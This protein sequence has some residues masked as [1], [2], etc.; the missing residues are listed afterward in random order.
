VDVGGESTRPGA[1]PVTDEEQIRRV[2]P[3]IEPLAELGEVSIDTRSAAVARAAVRAGARIINDVSA[4]LELVAAELGAGWVAMH[5]RGTPQTMQRDTRYED[6]VA[7]VCEFL[8][9]RAQRG[10]ELGIDR[11]WIDPGFGFGKTPTQNLQLLSATDRLAA[12]GFPVLVGTS[13]KSTL[14]ILAAAVRAG[15]DEQAP[16]TRAVASAAAGDRLEMSIV[17]A[18][19]A[20][21]LGAD[22]VRVHDVEATLGA[23]AAFNDL[24]KPAADVPHP[25]ANGHRDRTNRTREDEF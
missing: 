25:A 10:V 7:T 5:M 20:A 22:M 9:E 1:A 6:V 4:S 13:R 15:L 17:T 16:E 2:V 23:F 21:S 19:L 3:V 11:I 24:V 18:L 8:V 12:S 14:G